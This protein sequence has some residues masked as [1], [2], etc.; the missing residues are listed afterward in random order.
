LLVFPHHFFIFEFVLLFNCYFVHKK[1]CSQGHLVLA[2]PTHSAAHA[3]SPASTLADASSTGEP[4]GS[5]VQGKSSI[6]ELHLRPLPS[7][8]NTTALSSLRV[9]NQTFRCAAPQRYLRH[10]INTPPMQTLRPYLV[11]GLLDGLAQA[12]RLRLSLRF[13]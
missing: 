13:S 5:V 2:W 1:V 6:P 9:L 12:R 10:L 7:L 11:T 4:A 8:N 3:G